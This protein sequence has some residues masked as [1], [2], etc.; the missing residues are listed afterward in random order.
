MEKIVTTM[1]ELKAVPENDIAIIE[2][3][4]W[5]L[6][7]DYNAEIWVRGEARISSIYGNCQIH[8]A[9]GNCQ[10][11]DAYGN[12]QIHHAH[13]N[14]QIYHAFGNCQI[15]HA[16][17][18][19]QIH[20]AHENCQI[21]HAYGNCQIHDAYGNCQIHNAYDFVQVKGNKPH[22]LFGNARMIE[23]PTTINEWIKFNGVEEEEG[24]VYLYKAV[25]ENY[26]DFYTGKIK[27]EGQVIC[28]DWKEENIECGYGLHLSR[29]IPTAIFF[30]PK[31]KKYRLIQCK[32]LK[33]NIRI[34]TK[35]DILYPFKIRVKKI[36]L[37]KEVNNGM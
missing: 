19:C 10:I 35:N 18:N 33:E 29:N 37:I 14:C 24:S 36:E 16:Y 31:D 34:Y 25:D 23:Y 30:V 28:P 9:Y 7:E 3:G 21:H 26:H 4:S 20:H 8:H 11:H 13:G 22:K 12:C 15:Y 17:G 6:C 32:I 1:N 27:Y 5:K 2:S